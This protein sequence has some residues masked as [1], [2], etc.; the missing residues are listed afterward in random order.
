M[1]TLEQKIKKNAAING[2]LF[3]VI[4]LVLGIFLFYFI[5]LMTT[6]FWMITIIGPLSI[7]VLIPLGIAIWL[8]FDLRKKI[9]GFWNFKQATTGIFIM[10]LVT[11]L[12]STIGNLGF[13]TLIEPDMAQ[14]MKTVFINGTTTMMK[15]QGVDHDKIDKQVEQV[16]K[17][18]D[19]Q[20]DHS[21][22]TML[23]GAGI[24]IIIDFVLALIFAAMFKKEPLLYANDTDE[25][26]NA[27]LDPTL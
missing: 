27:G 13:S 4:F 6:N 11:Y 2:V 17:S 5:T 21:P 12:V 15:K 14:K 7:T 20:S 16:E 9:G 19:K 18:M 3:G 1:E 26:E 8:C 22:L 23:K 25:V 24:A 10:F